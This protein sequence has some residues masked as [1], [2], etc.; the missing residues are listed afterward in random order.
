MNFILVI[1]N[2]HHNQSI[3]N[4]FYYFIIKIQYYLIPLYFYYNLMKLF[5]FPIINK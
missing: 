1:I 2:I 4:Q 3:V 5:T